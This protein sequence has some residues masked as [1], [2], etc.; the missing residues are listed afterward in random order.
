MAPLA[1]YT[2]GIQI[3]Q[4]FNRGERGEAQRWCY[5]FAFHGALGGLHPWNLDLA[6]G[7]TAESAERR[8]EGEGKRI[9]FPYFL[10]VKTR[11]FSVLRI[12]FV[13]VTLCCHSGRLSSCYEQSDDILFSRKGTPSGTAGS[14]A[15]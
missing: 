3:L 14:R 7:L 2:S 12:F 5:S 11:P 13:H 15:I 1:V 4:G 8:R 10:A 9:I 6:G